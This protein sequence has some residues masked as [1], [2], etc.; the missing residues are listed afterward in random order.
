MTPMTT[1]P[2]VLDF[3]VIEQ[4]RMNARI[5]RSTAFWAMWASARVAIASRLASGG[6]A[7]QLPTARA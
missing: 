5:E 7:D 1:N 4:I 2:T 6:G 3:N